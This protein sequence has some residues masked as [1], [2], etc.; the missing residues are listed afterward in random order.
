MVVFQN[1]ANTRNICARSSLL[2]QKICRLNF[3]CQAI[4]FTNVVLRKI[5]EQITKQMVGKDC[6][7][8]NINMKLI[9][10]CQGPVKHEVMDIN[11]SIGNSKSI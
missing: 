8:T 11:W 10:I 3:I 6:D 5:Q 2:L 7:Y 1:L 4:Y 9:I